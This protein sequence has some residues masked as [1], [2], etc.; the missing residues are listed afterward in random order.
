MF[1]SCLET[2]YPSATAQNIVKADS[3][4]TGCDH[5]HVGR[6]AVMLRW[7]P[8]L[9]RTEGS[10]FTI[11]C[12]NVRNVSDNSYFLIQPHFYCSKRSKAEIN[13]S[14]LKARQLYKYPCANAENLYPSL[15]DYQVLA[16][17]CH[18][19]KHQLGWQS[20]EQRV[21]GFST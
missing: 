2:L 1:L 19:R 20:Q 4:T 17:L 6:Q 10:K 8:G 16:Q 14:A 7:V 21:F 12:Y 15:G 13:V 11:H 18:Y 5:V 9:D 3:S